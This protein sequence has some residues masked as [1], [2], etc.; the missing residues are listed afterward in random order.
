MEYLAGKDNTCVGLLSR[1]PKQLEDESVRV[2]LW[3]DGRVY[4]IGV[5]NA[6]WLK[7][8]PVLGTDAEEDT[9]AVTDPHW[10]KEIE[11]G[12]MDSEKTALREK[13]YNTRR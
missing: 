5:I 10:M 11:K 4:Q 2:E 13:V 7:D 6:N 8:R 12:Q 9:Q 3:V 1:I